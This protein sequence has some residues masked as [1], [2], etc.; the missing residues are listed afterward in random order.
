MAELALNTSSQ[1]GDVL[2]FQTNDN[3]D[4]DVN[5]GIVTMTPSFETALYLS[6]FG[7]NQDDAGGSDRTLQWWGDIDE[8]EP[9]RKYISETQNLIE[10][11]PV[12]S[13]NLL[14]IEDAARRDLAWLVNQGIAS[15]VTVNA[16]IPGLNRVRIDIVIS[17]EGEET[18]FTFTE[19]WKASRNG[20]TD[21]N[22]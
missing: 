13:S 4:I 8:V 9:A 22:N 5:D 2:L 20:L 19:N 10:G 17:A 7:G 11:L 12:T 18:T 15:S 16:S 6:L 3:G 1:D 14:R 21:P